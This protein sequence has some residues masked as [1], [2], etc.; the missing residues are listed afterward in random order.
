[1]NSV[2]MTPYRDIKAESFAGV[3]KVFQ[4]YLQS[5]Y[6]SLPVPTIYENGVAVSHMV[7]GLT[8]N[9]FEAPYFWVNSSNREQ[10]K[11]LIMFGMER[12]P[13]GIFYWH[14]D[15]DNEPHLQSSNDLVF[16]YSQ[17]NGQQHSRGKLR[18][19]SSPLASTDI[20]MDE[21]KEYFP[22]SD[23]WNDKF[24]FVGLEI[25]GK[26]V[27]IL[28]YS[29]QYDNSCVIQ[30]VVTADSLRGK[31]Y[32]TELVGSFS[33]SVSCMES[34]IYYVCD[35]KNIAS[36]KTVVKAGFKESDSIKV[37]QKKEC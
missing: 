36:V 10:A 14:G 4:G 18:W 37:L 17:D 25:D 27:S 30:K 6:P 20:L 16:I 22:P 32:G 9:A 11:Q 5:H 12:I 29:V 26:L 13:S 34:G 28:D 33:Q 1:M 19:I 2:V 35:E 3:Q 7:S 21:L 23:F 24:R 8:V 15:L 31:G